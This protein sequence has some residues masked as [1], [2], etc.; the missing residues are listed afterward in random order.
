MSSR[1]RS[2]GRTFRP[3]LTLRGIA[4]ACAAV[5][6]LVLA[7]ALERRE[8]LAL[9]FFL[10]LMPALAALLLA[11]GRPRLSVTRSFE[12]DTVEAGRTVQVRLS[13]R[14]SG[15]SASPESSWFDTVPPEVGDTPSAELPV[16]GGTVLR[17]VA[18]AEAAVELGYGLEPE[19]RG[20]YPIGPF[21]VASQDPFGLV[22]RTVEVGE[23]TPLVVTPRV[24]PLPDVP[25]GRAVADGSAA[26]LQR[27]GIAGDDD[28][29]T[30]EYR[31]GDA[32]RRVHWRSTAR[33]GE[34]MVRQ[35]E[36]R[37]DP[38]AVVFLDT[39][40]RSY[41]HAHG[42][43]VFHGALRRADDFERAIEL[44]AS[45]TLHLRGAGYEVDVLQSAARTDW[46]VRPREAFGAPGGVE[47]FL[48]GL[49]TLGSTPAVD[50]GFTDR[51]SGELRR[52]GGGTPLFAVLGSAS[53]TEV[54]RLAGMRSL[55]D[56]AVAFFVTNDSLAD[57]EAVLT[58]AGWICVRVGTGDDL[59]AAW[60]SIGERR[61]RHERV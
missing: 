53:A 48:A 42:I 28:L 23:P 6:C 17:T 31:P 7:Y 16:L 55:A 52:R 2:A 13:V 8:L 39:R 4:F 35:E 61:M 12:P 10:A 44:C 47:E 20:V 45:V 5:V 46:L 29:I 37:S 40:H 25:F 11:V 24:T 50:R 34:L 32:K 18:G 3:R 43:G 36:P 38:E 58:G 33:F 22:L 54:E 41:P 49:A 26:E 60:R 51:L 1:G 19:R 59:G 14:N 57:E 15:N 27:H 9:G 56:P 30:R 21:V